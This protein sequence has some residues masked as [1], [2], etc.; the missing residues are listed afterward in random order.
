M[1]LNLDYIVL[2]F[3]KNK[4]KKCTDI[5]GNSKSF[6]RVVKRS[7]S[8]ALVVNNLSLEDMEAWRA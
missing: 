2:I 4:N 6:V 8:L 1:F 7:N 3:A 5:I